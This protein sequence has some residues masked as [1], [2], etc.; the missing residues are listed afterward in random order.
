MKRI[1]L[2]VAILSV[3]AV[4]NA[5]TIQVTLSP[6]QAAV[7]QSLTDTANASI[8]DTNALNVERHNSAV[9]DINR[10]NEALA[11]EDPPGTPLPA[12]VAT[13]VIPSVTVASIVEDAFQSLLDNMVQQSLQEEAILLNESCVND[14][15]VRQRLRNARDR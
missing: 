15:A 9:T 13:P 4:A 11:L 1:I 7:A 10:Q 12:P 8:A 2:L 6:N 5:Q 14:P 3:S